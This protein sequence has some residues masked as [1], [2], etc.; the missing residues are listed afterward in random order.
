MTQYCM[1]DDWPSK[2]DNMLCVRGWYI[3]I[4]YI[5]ASGPCAQTI[6]MSADM[7]VVIN[8]LNIKYWYCIFCECVHLYIYAAT[9]LIVCSFSVLKR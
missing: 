4:Q 8:G 9:S 1:Y 7:K 2:I 3:F 5:E 6:V